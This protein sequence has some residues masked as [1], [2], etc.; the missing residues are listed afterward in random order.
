MRFTSFNGIGRTW[1]HPVELRQNTPWMEGQRSVASLLV[2]GHKHYL[3]S[4]S[5][6]LLGLAAS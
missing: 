3:L 5:S 6:L 1:P 4:F 2:I